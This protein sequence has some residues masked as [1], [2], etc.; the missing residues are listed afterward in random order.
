[1]KLHTKYENVIHPFSWSHIKETRELEEKRGK[2]C[3]ECKSKDIKFKQ[4]SPDLGNLYFCSLK[5]YKKFSDDNLYRAVE[6]E[7]L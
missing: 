7:D 1:M 5:H 4:F 3:A 6:I 2:V